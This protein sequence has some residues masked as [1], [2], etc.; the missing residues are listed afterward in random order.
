MALRQI[1]DRS[2][3]DTREFVHRYLQGSIRSTMD[4]RLLDRARCKGHLGEMVALTTAARG[5]L[6]ELPAQDLPDSPPP[7]PASNNDDNS[8]DELEGT[9]SGGTTRPP[10]S[11]GSDVDAG[12]GDAPD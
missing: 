12:G 9:A 10:S 3:R 4:L 2:A 8:I 5:D 7:T 6:P 11:H 1:F